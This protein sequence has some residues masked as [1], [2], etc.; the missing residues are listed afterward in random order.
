MT[1]FS[2]RAAVPDFDL[3]A[4]NDAMLTGLACEDADMVG[5]PAW[6]CAPLAGLPPPPVAR[7]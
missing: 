1:A 2:L 6:S 7:A 4:L 3:P 5:D